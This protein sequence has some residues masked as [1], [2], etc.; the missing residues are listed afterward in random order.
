MHLSVVHKSPFVH[1]YVCLYL[2]FCDCVYASMAVLYLCW[3]FTHVRVQ[4][5]PALAAGCTVVAKPSE[6]TP[7]TASLLA[8]AAVRAGLPPGVLNVVHGLGQD[9]GSELVG[10]SGGCL[11]A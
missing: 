8:E 4:I 3:S 2:Y 6:F 9:V 1:I 11:T 5:A 7:T 10:H